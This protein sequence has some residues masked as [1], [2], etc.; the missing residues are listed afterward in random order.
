MDKKEEIC[1]NKVRYVTKEE[2]MTSYNAYRFF[3]QRNRGR[4]VK[5][6]KYKQRPY[7]CDICGGWH[8]TTIR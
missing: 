7:K 3:S 5:K 1:L 8:L 2:A 6:E 4:R